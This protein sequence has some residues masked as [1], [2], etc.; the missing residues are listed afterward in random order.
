MAVRE[1]ETIFQAVV[2]TVRGQKRLHVTFTSGEIVHLSQPQMRAYIARAKEPQIRRDI[3]RQLLDADPDWNNP[4][5]LDG[6]AFERDDT[7]ELA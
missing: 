4:A 5:R 1:T 7:R 2:T 3:F 6:V